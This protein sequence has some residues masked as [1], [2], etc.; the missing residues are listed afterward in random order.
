MRDRAPHQITFSL[1]RPNNIQS[2]YSKIRTECAKLRSNTQSTQIKRKMK[3]ITIFGTTL[4]AF[5]VH[6][7]AAL[8]A[9]ATF[10]NEDFSGFGF[11]DNSNESGV[12]FSRTAGAGTSGSFGGVVTI[13]TTTASAFAGGGIQTFNLGLDPA[14]TAGSI[15]VEQLSSLAYQF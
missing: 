13:G 7:S 14:F 10:E 12:A 4:L 5:S 1:Y 15:T 11:S 9:N 2:K 3:S 8:I 6:A